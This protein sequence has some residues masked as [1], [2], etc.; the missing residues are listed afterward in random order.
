MRSCPAGRAA[1]GEEEFVSS[2]L[3]SRTRQKIAG[4]SSQSRRRQSY[5]E[6]RN[7]CS[8]TCSY[9]ALGRHGQAQGEEDAQAGTGSQDGLADSCSGIPEFRPILAG[10]VGRQFFAFPPAVV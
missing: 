10:L 1:R 7:P 6:N 8:S 2:R 4:P 3:F 9:R 5:E